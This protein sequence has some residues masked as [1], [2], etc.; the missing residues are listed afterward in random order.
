VE[1]RV[2]LTARAERDLNFLYDQI[3]AAE[4]TAAER[5]FNGLEEAIYTLD[6]LPHRCPLAP[7]GKR[8]GNSLRHLLYGRKP[9]VYRIIYAIDQPRRMVRILTIRHGA[10]AAAELTGL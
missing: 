9:D 7:E 5:W 3:H 10:M 8:T 2:D 1:Y 6:R 4:S